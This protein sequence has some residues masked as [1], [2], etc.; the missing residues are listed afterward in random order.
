MVLDLA[1][2]AGGALAVSESAMAY[3]IWADYRIEKASG[4][5]KNFGEYFWKGATP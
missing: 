4:K 5:V 3:S 1:L 2:I